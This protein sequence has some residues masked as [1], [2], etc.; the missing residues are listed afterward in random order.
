MET[1]THLDFNLSWIFSI[2]REG[3]IKMLSLNLLVLASYVMYC[4]ATITSGEDEDYDNEEEG[5]IFYVCKYINVVNACMDR[6]T[7]TRL[8]YFRP[9]LIDILKSVFKIESM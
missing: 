8:S 6:E 4:L 9:L 7:L 1:K 3:N 2:G 5:S